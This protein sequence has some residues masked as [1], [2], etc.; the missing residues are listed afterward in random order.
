MFPQ[1]ANI[2]K[3]NLKQKV[4]VSPIILNGEYNSTERLLLPA[5]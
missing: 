2:L 3:G 1:V 5:K 4:S